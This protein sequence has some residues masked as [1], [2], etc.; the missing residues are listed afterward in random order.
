VF[1][2]EILADFDFYGLFLPPFSRLD[3]PL[4]A[5]RLEERRFMRKSACARL[6][7]RM[8]EKTALL[9][10]DNRAVFYFTN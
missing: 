5:S 10:N 8:T 4:Y 6:S 3:V 7:I 1:F 2:V 9:S